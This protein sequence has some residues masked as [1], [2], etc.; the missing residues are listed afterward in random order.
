M[1]GT[2]FSF[3]R[4]V[5]IIG[6]RVLSLSF[7]LTLNLLLFSLARYLKHEIAA[8]SL[9]ENEPGRF[10]SLNWHPELALHLVL[11]TPSE[12]DFVRVDYKFERRNQEGLYNGHIHGIRLLLSQSLL[13]ILGLLL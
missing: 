1:K 11:T 12:S 8:P 6:E 4:Q 13:S 5:I 2:L 3:G 10:T 7:W 9:S